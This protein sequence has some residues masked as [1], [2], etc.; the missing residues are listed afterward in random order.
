M[1]IVTNIQQEFKSIGET[2]FCVI[3][4]KDNFPCPICGERLYHYDSRKRSARTDE[5][6]YYDF[7]LRRLRCTGCKKIHLELPDFL[8]PNQRCFK[9][10]IER[11][12]Q[13]K[14]VAVVKDP[15]TPQRWRRWWRRF[16]AHLRAAVHSLIH[17]QL[18]D[19]RIL[20]CPLPDLAKVLVNHQLWPFHLLWDWS[21][22]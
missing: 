5:D 8:L 16:G 13:N 6:K 7:I 22:P 2:R 11:A 14:P 17:R 19:E 15:R 4:G 9:S 18:L 20:E 1:V 10:V 3:Q 12:L 21:P